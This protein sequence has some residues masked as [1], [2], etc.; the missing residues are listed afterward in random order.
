MFHKH[1]KCPMPFHTPCHLPCMLNASMHPDGSLSSGFK[2]GGA[3]LARILGSSLSYGSPEFSVVL[4]KLRAYRKQDTI[5]DCLLHGLLLGYAVRPTM[6][7]LFRRPPHKLNL[8]EGVNL[9][10]CN[11]VKRDFQTT[12]L[13]DKCPV[14]FF[15][16]HPQGLA[17]CHCGKL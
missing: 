3:E 17:L 14:A 4:G 8:S 5:E 9:E 6:A 10:L 2:R 13:G 12:L 1:H 15:W 7:H 16:S 11:E